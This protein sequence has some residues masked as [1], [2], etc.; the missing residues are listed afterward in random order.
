[1]DSGFYT[2]SMYAA[3]EF[4]LGVVIAFLV[5]YLFVLVLGVASYVMTSLGLYKIAKRREI[6]DPWMAWLP[7][8]CDWLIGKIA[9][10]YDGRNGVK[11]KWSVVLLTLSII[12]VV[13]F[14]AFY[15]ALIVWIVILTMNSSEP[16]LTEML[17]VFI[18]LYVGILVF[19]MV[20]TAQGFCKSICVYKIFESTVP[21]KSVAYFL[22]YLLVPLAGPICLLTCSKKGYPFPEELVPVVEVPVE[23][24]PVEVAV[25]EEQE[26]VL[27]DNVP[28]VES[29]ESIFEDE[30]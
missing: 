24:V 6:P 13:G 4:A 26:V 16:A 5:T 18:G 14:V 27:E 8:A 9:D 28:E 12:S 1:M 25:A 11:R 30:I 19:A 17:G 22:L 7:F 3:E 20:G 29:E 2:D 23:K 10:E 15:V 21:E